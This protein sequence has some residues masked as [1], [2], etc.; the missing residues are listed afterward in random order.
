MK[1]DL[2]KV[3]HG[4]DGLPIK[5]QDDKPATMRSM[6][7]YALNTL[8]FQE[9]QSAEEKAAIYALSVKLS[10]ADSVDLT[11]DERTLVKKRAGLT[12]RP[13]TLGPVVAALEDPAEDKPTQ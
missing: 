2:S 3:I 1:I 6:M 12:L 7:L 10:G 5:D 9:H 4:Y 8:G 13:V 11:L